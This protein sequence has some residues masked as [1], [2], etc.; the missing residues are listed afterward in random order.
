MFWE[1]CYFPANLYLKIISVLLRSTYLRKNVIFPAITGINMCRAP[2]NHIFWGKMLLSL[3]ISI[4]KC[5]KCFLKSHIF[6]KIVTFPASLPNSDH[7]CPQN[8]LQGQATPHFP[9]KHSI[10]QLSPLPFPSCLPNTISCCCILTQSPQQ[11]HRAR[12]HFG[13]SRSTF[14]CHKHPISKKPNQPQ[15]ASVSL[16]KFLKNINPY[17][18]GEP[19]KCIFFPNPLLLNWVKC[20]SP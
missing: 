8:D 20:K 9:G 16:N 15:K 6:G 11:W 10:A 5:V 17:N 13:F 2:Q 14:Q 18:L 1:K 4:L 19:T 7:S 3:Q 12:I